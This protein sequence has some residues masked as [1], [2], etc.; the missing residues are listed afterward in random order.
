M[1]QK[2]PAPTYQLE[3]YNT[4]GELTERTGLIFAYRSSSFRRAT[5]GDEYP[6]TFLE[7]ELMKN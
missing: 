1:G 5:I 6:T 4:I 3:I 7:G 2:Q